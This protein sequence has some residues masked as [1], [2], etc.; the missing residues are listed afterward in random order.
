[1]RLNAFKWSYLQEEQHERIKAEKI[2]IALEKLRA[3]RVKKLVV[4][5]YNDEDPTSKTVAIDQTW[6]AWEVCK[7]MM[8]KND[9]E[10]DPNWVLIERIPQLNIG[11]FVIFFIIIFVQNLLQLHMYIIYINYAQTLRVKCPCITSK[12]L[13]CHLILYIVQ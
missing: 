2:R 9:T 13:F 7:K 8:R 11:W 10:P 4:K 1:M 3:A 12:F 6:T 5:V